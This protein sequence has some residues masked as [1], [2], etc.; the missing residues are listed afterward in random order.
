MAGM[1]AIKK[2]L[3]FFQKRQTFALA[4]EYIAKYGFISIKD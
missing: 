4:D 2:E 3:G 1:A